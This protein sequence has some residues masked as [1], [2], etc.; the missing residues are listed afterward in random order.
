MP[1]IIK[2]GDQIIQS[3]AFNFDDMAAKAG[4]YLDKV[5]A[6]AAQVLVRAKQDAVTVRQK[7]EQEGRRQAQTAIEQM[8]EARAQEL[9]AGQM[10]TLLPA[11]RQVIQDLHHARQTWLS[12]W[13]RSAVH[14][15]AAIASRLIRRELSQ[16]PEITLALV[17][18]AM[19]LAA[20]SP[21][22]R[23]HL[24]PQD[25]QSLGPQVQAL[26]RELATVGTPEL[27]ADPEISAGGCRVETRF[28]VIDQQFEA[29]LAR[30]EEEL[31]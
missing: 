14:V 13:E 31:T 11:L 1:T 3:V 15:A 28:G 6:E 5:R 12:H 27:I 20:G 24:N 30:I 17:R 25:H 2:A 22:I 21:Q 7:A 26:F 10:Q 18:E 23:V 29:Q 9:V 8:V 4:Q 19:E 16:A